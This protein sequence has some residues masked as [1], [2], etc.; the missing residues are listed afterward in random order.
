VRL[1]ETIDRWSQAEKEQEGDRIAEP[2][3]TYVIAKQLP[4]SFH[5]PY[6]ATEEDVEAYLAKLKA[7][8]IKAI[9]DG[10]R[11]QL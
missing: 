4:V 1:L 8:M 6:L 3:P 11:I 9:Q 10:K 7:A 5:R 2:P